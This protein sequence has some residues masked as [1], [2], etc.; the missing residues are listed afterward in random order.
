MGTPAQQLRTAE[1]LFMTGRFEEAAA[2]YDGLRDSGAP[3]GAVWRRLGQIALLADLQNE[4]EALLMQAYRREPEPATLQLLG[5]LYVRA[6]RFPEAAACLAGLGRE[7]AAQALS[8]FGEREPYACGGE[9]ARLPLVPE[10]AMP[11]VQVAINGV[12]V[13]LLVDTGAQE[14]VLDAGVAARAG[15]RVG[16]AEDAM[17]S[18]GRLASFRHG[19]LDT[20]ALGDLTLSS[21]PVHV[22]ALRDTFRTFAPDLPV[23]GILGTAVLYRFRARLDRRAGVLELTPRGGERGQ[24]DDGVP[25][26][27]AGSHLPVVPAVVNGATRALMVVDTG[28]VGLG[29]VVSPS[30]AQKAGA[31]SI[32]ASAQHG[33]GGGGAVALR[34]LQLEEVSV[35]GLAARE[36]SGACMPGFPLEHHF[37]FRIGGLLSYD[38]LAGRAAELDFASMR[39]VL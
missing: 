3:G 4:A 24:R 37:G 27:L 12:A 19:M 36:I 5:D 10:I 28:Q 22:Q 38:L 15:V 8:G 21:L 2:Y 34:P 14:L 6:R 18:G 31:Q 20:L 35:G 1:A 16:P 26:W 11:L 29:C 9:R 25:L 23:E 7:A 33:Q 30:I 32:D 39:F 17:H 13:T